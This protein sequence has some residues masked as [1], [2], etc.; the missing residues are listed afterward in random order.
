MKHFI[1]DVCDAQENG[2]FT[3]MHYK[4]NWHFDIWLKNLAFLDYRQTSLAQTSLGPWKLFETWVVRV[5]K[6]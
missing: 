1:F 5:N 3:Q 4:L 2:M 6:D